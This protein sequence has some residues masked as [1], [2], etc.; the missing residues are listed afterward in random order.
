METKENITETQN[1]ESDSEEQVI[2]PM[3]KNNGMEKKDLDFYDCRTHKQLTD[4]HDMCKN[5]I[6]MGIDI[7]ELNRKPPKIPMKDDKKVYILFLNN[8]RDYFHSHCKVVSSL[9]ELVDEII[10]IFNHFCSRYHLTFNDILN[11]KSHNEEDY[12]HMWNNHYQDGDMPLVTYYNDNKCSRY[13]I[14]ISHLTVAEFDKMYV[15]LIEKL[16][17]G[18]HK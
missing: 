11:N 16:V 7:N 4:Y 5:L 17:E 18:R 9:K 6:A 1:N 13:T 10:E 12:F 14:T 2:K 8:Y 3:K 15:M